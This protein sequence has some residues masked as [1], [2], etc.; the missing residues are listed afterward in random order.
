MY[1][2]QS[3]HIEA[4]EA[5]LPY[6][7]DMDTVHC[8]LEWAASAKKTKLVKRL[9]QHPGIDINAGPRGYTPLHHA[10]KSKDLDLIETLINAGADPSIPY[11]QR[12]P[13]SFPISG[14][15]GDETDENW[16][17]TSTLELSCRRV[18][19]GTEWPRF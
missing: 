13:C 14:Y 5:F 8:A 11:I 7:E 12:R 19:F 9:I 17:Y 15:D 2:C 10:C 4:V 6:L 16:E 3:G 1:A 18:S